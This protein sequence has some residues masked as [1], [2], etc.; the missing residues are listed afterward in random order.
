VNSASKKNLEFY[1]VIIIGAG[2]GGISAA[3]K[4]KKENIPVLIL[5]ALDRIGGRIYTKQIP[6]LGNPAI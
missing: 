2:M 1:Q 5:E 4:L 3:R 6:N